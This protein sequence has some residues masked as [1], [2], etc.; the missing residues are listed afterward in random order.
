MDSSRFAA[1]CRALGTETTRRGAVGV[2]AGLVGL[3]IAQD[4][5][6]ERKQQRRRQR[7]RSK[8]QRR[9]Q[10]R[11][12][13]QAVDCVGTLTRAGCSR[14]SVTTYWGCP[15]DT[16]LNNANLRGCDLRHATLRQ[17]FLNDADLD[18]AILNNA[19]LDGSQAHGIHL[20]RATMVEATFLGTNMGAGYFSGADMRKANFTGASLNNAYLDEDAVQ[21]DA[22]F[23]DA[24]LRDVVWSQLWA[25]DIGMPIS[26][27]R[28]NCPDRVRPFWPVTCCGHLNG[29]T[30]PYC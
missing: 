17:I 28:A 26:Y 10:R 12:E 25:P 20:E 16:N 5:D 14:D 6:G 4:V 21:Y 22:I 23:Q 19:H 11:S 1:L 8:Q 13:L 30:T 7:R 2:L 29:Y 15:R 3:G 27:G 24:D 18:F 9:T